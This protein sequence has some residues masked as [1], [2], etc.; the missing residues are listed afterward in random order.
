LSPTEVK[1]LMRRLWVGYGADPIGSSV[2]STGQFILNFV[3]GMVV[4]VFSI[5]AIQQTENI[6]I[7]SPEVNAPTRECLC[8]SPRPT[9]LPCCPG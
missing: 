8:E 5:I 6:G 9:P 7:A 1:M 3:V 4:V 2:I